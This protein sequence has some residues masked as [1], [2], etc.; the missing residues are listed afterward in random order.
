MHSNI[1]SFCDS[2]YSSETL[3]RWQSIKWNNHMQVPVAD[4]N[5]KHSNKLDYSNLK[6]YL[7]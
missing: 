7:I 6:A 3:S 5:H 4:N 1:L 2:C